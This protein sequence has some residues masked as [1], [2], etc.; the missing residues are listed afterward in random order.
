MK[1]HNVLTWG[2]FKR[3][4][5]PRKKRPVVWLGITG[6]APRPNGLCLYWGPRAYFVSVL[7]RP[8]TWPKKR[9]RR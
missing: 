8:W 9:S 4:A 1:A 5:K 7:P 3:P 6:R 2:S